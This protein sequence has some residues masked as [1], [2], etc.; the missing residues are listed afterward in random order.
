[1]STTNA[2][3]Y[4]RRVSVAAAPRRVY[5]ALTTLTGLAGW[6]TPLVEGDPGEGGGLAFRFRGLD[7]RILMRVDVA[8]SPDRVLWRCLEH[9]GHP[10]WQGTRIHFQ[11]TPLDDQ[12]ATLEVRHEGL[13]PTL[14]CYDVCRAGWDGFLESIAAYAETGKGAPFA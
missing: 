9:S 12:T 14:D 11:I 1:M 3:D 13:I 7:E 6:W 8:R 4:Q 5:D 10:E 2:P